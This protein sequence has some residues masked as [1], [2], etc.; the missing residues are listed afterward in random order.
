[1][2]QQNAEIMTNSYA[3]IILLV[4]GKSTLNEEDTALVKNKVLQTIVAL[5]DF[6]S[7][8]KILSSGDLGT[9]FNNLTPEL[10]RDISDFITSF[11]NIGSDVAETLIYFSTSNAKMTDLIKRFSYVSNQLIVTSS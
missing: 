11:M 4:R 9:D 6:F 2:N 3:D 10:T 7:K 5:Q 1:L 8:T